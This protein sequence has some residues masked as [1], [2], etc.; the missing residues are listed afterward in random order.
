MPMNPLTFATHLAKGA[1]D[2]LQRL[3]RQ[4]GAPAHLK[5]DRTVV[6]EADFQSDQWI[7]KTI[8]ETYP[9]DGILSEEEGTR[10]PANQEFVWVIDPLDGTANFSLGLHHWGVSIA[11]LKNGFPH[12][13]AIYFPLLDELFLA[14]EGGGAFLNHSPLQVDPES[15]A[16][17]ATCFCC[18]SRTHRRYHVNI[19]YKTRILGSAAYGLCTVARGSATFAFEATPKVWDF[20]ASWLVTLEAGGVIAPIEGQSP[21]PL[22]PGQDYEALSFPLLVAPTQELWLAGC[23]QIKKK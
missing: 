23:Q 13:A 16:K 22:V 11:R 2:I 5:D 12:L 6:T 10:F 21:F 8:R 4:Q 9:E 7:R 20:A 17:P 19:R 3:Y 1:G 14:S 18:C 15:P